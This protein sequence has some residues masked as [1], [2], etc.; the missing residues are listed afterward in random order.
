M[1]SHILEE[2]CGIC[3]LDTTICPLKYKC[4]HAFCMQCLY[5]NRKNIVLRKCPLCRTPDPLIGLT[6]SPIYYLNDTVDF[7]QFYSDFT[8]K[9]LTKIEA[10]DLIN[11]T[12]KYV[13]IEYSNYDPIKNFTQNI[14]YIGTLTSY[15]L[16][17]ITLSNCHHL[18]KDLRQIYPTMPDIRSNILIRSGITIYAEND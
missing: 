9:T 2:A 11:K 18:N 16:T 10:S 1:A 12:G 7:E 13:V 5:P 6:N 17:R 15:S 4:G 3:A 14:A 8:R